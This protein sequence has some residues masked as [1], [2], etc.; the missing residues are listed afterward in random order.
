M[1]RVDFEELKQI[2]AEIRAIRNKSEQDGRQMSR[3]EKDMLEQ[4]AA[5]KEDLLSD[6]IFHGYG[7]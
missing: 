2:S 6:T 7:S 1:S 5:N 3:K 4:L